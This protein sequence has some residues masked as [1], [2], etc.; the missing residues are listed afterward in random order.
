MVVKHGW[1]ERYSNNNLIF[2]DMLHGC[3]QE[4][5]YLWKGKHEAKRLFGL[6]VCYEDILVEMWTCYL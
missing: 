3:V 6:E 1:N 4:N 2:I 5:F